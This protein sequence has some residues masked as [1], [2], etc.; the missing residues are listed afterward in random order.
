MKNYE[1][2]FLLHLANRIG[3]PMRGIPH[4]PRY[5]EHPQRRARRIVLRGFHGQWWLYSVL[6]EDCFG[7]LA[8]RRPQDDK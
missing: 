5:D 7:F 6:M 8:P 3:V 1:I 4:H 2:L